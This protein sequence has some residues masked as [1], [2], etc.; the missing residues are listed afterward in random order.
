[1][2]GCGGADEEAAAEQ[3]TGVPLEAQD[4]GPVHVHGLG[5]D[6]KRGILYIA[7]HTGAAS[8]R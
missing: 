1:V 7:T 8:G 2:T 6:A 3:F 5:Y 4:P